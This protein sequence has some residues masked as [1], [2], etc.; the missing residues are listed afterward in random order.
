MSERPHQHVKQP[1]HRDE[2][3]QPERRYTEPTGNSLWKLTISVNTAS[4]DSDPEE[5]AATQDPGRV[6][7]QRQDQR[8]QQGALGD[9]P[10]HG[11]GDRHEH[12]AGPEGKDVE[13]QRPPR[14]ED[15]ERNLPLCPRPERGRDPAVVANRHHGHDA[16]P[17]PAP[18]SVRAGGLTSRADVGRVRAHQDGEPQV[19]ARGSELLGHGAQALGARSARGHEEDGVVRPAGQRVQRGSGVDPDERQDDLCPLAGRL[20][21]G[22]L[23]R[24]AA[25]LTGRKSGD[26]ASPDQVHV[27]TVRREAPGRRLRPPAAPAGRPG[28]GRPRRR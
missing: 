12:S 14:P 27:A 28:S 18:P 9:H 6:G 11:P 21:T 23:L 1:Q 3:H 5:D 24:P 8:Q 19:H 22:Q 17:R 13:Q 16:V 4:T 2:A 26:A 20:R 7:R 10:P 15:Q 25:G